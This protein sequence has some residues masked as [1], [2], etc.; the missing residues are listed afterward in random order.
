LSYKQGQI[1][2]KKGARSRRAAAMD[3]YSDIDVIL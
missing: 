3:D 1:K 2:R